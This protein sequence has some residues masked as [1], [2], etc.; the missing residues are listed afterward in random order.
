MTRTRTGAARDRE[1]AEAVAE[2][3]ALIRVAMPKILRGTRG[4]K[5]EKKALAAKKKGV[6]AKYPQ[7]S[8]RFRR[9]FD[10]AYQRAYNA[11]SSR[12]AWRRVYDARKGK[13]R[14]DRKGAGSRARDAEKQKHRY[15]QQINDEKNAI[16]NRPRVEGE[17]AII[18]PEQADAFAQ[19]L[20]DKKVAQLDK[21]ADVPA[22]W[23][24]R[25]LLLNRTV[26]IGYT[27]RPVNKEALCWIRRVTTTV[28][29]FADDGTFKGEYRRL[30]E[31]MHG[32][33]LLLWGP[34]APDGHAQG[35]LINKK[36]AREVLKFKTL[37]VCSFKGAHA[38]LS[39]RTVE[40][41]LQE[42]F[43]DLP[44]GRRCWKKVDQGAW[45]DKEEDK[46]CDHKV[47]VDFSAAVPDLIS[48]GVVEV[49]SR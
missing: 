23:T 5:K 24:L 46:G 29:V 44:P 14:K 49:N 8:G 43:H 26:Y 39:A 13:G 38:K 37:Q 25:D 17:D 16:A 21:K 28:P 11:Q 10:A 30:P 4:G 36:P 27:R 15:R 12:K 3:E 45:Q 7:E 18:G 32:Y 6:L 42:L 2:Y 40:A 20:L 31:H 1:V 47:Y 34:E 48:K 35:D 33:P 9:L 22:D 41:K 19:G